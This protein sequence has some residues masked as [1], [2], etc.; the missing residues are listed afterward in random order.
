[1]RAFSV[2]GRSRIRAGIQGRLVAALCPYIDRAVGDM[3]FSEYGFSEHSHARDGPAS[4][5]AEDL[6]H[7]LC[8]TGESLQIAADLGHLPQLLNLRQS[9]S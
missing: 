9:V 2:P 4:S 6:S 1:M 3:T 7:L 8:S 5:I